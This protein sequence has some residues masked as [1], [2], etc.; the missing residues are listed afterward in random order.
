MSSASSAAQA[1]PSATTP[2]SATVKE[3]DSPPGDESQGNGIGAGAGGPPDK[4][5]KPH[6]PLNRVPRA[7]NACRK[8]K[9]KCT[10]ADNP[11]CKRCRT[12]GIECV[13]EKPIRDTLNNSEQGMRIGRLETQVNSIQSTLSELVT[14]L[15]A[16]VPQAAGALGSH[17]PHPNTSSTSAQASHHHQ[18]SPGNYG[19]PSPST[20]AHST[21]VPSSHGT[22]GAPTD[23]QGPPPSHHYPGPPHTYNNQPMPSGMRQYRST[24]SS[25][26]NR[27]AGGYFSP[28]SHQPPH[29]SASPN[30]MSQ[31]P[32]QLPHLEHAHRNG[33]PVPHQPPM[34]D[35]RSSLH[36]HDQYAQQQP[37]QGQQ[38]HQFSAQ[39]Q[40]QQN[41]Q[42]QQQHHYATQQH[43]VQQQHPSM[44]PPTSL[45]PFSALDVPHGGAHRQTPPGTSPLNVHTGV[46]RA[47]PFIG[48][49]QRKGSGPPSASPVN[50]YN[51]IPPHG[52][53]LQQHQNQPSHAMMN[54]PSAMTQHHQGY[55]PPAGPQAH[56]YHSDTGDQGGGAGTKHGPAV[57][58]SS[59][60][61][62][63][64]SSDDEGG[65]SELPTHGM[66]A[67]FVAIRGLAD[68]AE[69][70]VEENGGESYPT[71]RSGSPS[72][73]GEYYDA[74]A[75]MHGGH[76]D[77]HGPL[78]DPGGRNG[79]RSSGKSGHGTD[80]PSKRRRI[81]SG[82]D[83]DNPEGPTSRAAPDV[84]TKGL[85]S[86]DEAR[87]L[88]QIFFT[89]CSM[90]LP[91]FDATMDT[92]DALH[93]RSP[94][95]V[96]V[97]CM[98]AS[99]VRDGGGPPSE[100][101]KACSKEVRELTCGT[102]F[103]PVMRQEV[104]QA[105]ILVA[106]WGAAPNDSGWLT[107]GHATRMALEL[108]IQKA[109]PRLL[110]RIHAGKMSTS[111]E[112]RELVI[113]S[114]T[115]FCLYL[116]EHQMSFG[117]GRPPVSKEDESVHDCRLL[118]THPLAITDDMRL[119]S[120][121]EL[122]IIRERTHNVVSPTN[123]VPIDSSTFAVLRQSKDNFESW[124]KIWSTNFS[125]KYDVAAFHR[126]SL[127]A[128]VAFAE[129]YHNA[130]ALRTIRGPDDV[131][132]I[133]EDQREVALRSIVV[134]RSALE[135]CLRS[136]SYREGMKYAVQY[137]H[138]S[139]TF[140]A[141]FLMRLARLFPDD[142]DLAA[143]MA[144][145]EDLAVILSEIPAT[146]F[147]RT[148]KLMIRS[149]KRRRVL[150]SS[151]NHDNSM[152][153]MQTD[154]MSRSTSTPRAN[155]FSPSEQALAAVPSFDQV[156]STNGEGYQ[157][158]MSYEGLDQFVRDFELMPGQ[159]VPVWLSE[160]NLGD[161]ALGQHGLEAF[162]I[163]PSLDEQRVVPEIW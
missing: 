102:L 112:E 47:G 27:A 34:P 151:R 110:K 22:G 41:L 163:P 74:D 104:V 58:S 49:P 160:S 7:C 124:L 60:V 39:Q 46:Q 97:I 123:N 134:A 108:G 6:R 2:P 111:Q 28:N 15:R 116:F 16:A 75:H 144:D 3:S 63:A 115:W 119:V 78:V 59:N 139:A 64:D 128:Q 121:V 100:T 20:S 118:L 32:Q 11:P 113:S 155:Q 88:F 150:P 146:R 152:G 44:P 156:M 56:H 120:M 37:H 43:Q 86:E 18:T 95:C 135:V 84:V 101:Y 94:F 138:L 10:D 125:R 70:A 96:D 55:G 31:Q 14:T 73:A 130:T 57:V 66:V 1:G 72:R 26:S 24:S 91:V 140:A 149:A 25:S 71:T 61:T 133:S 21:S 143:I 147:S 53:Q 117:T 103:A 129:L 107:C 85:I 131:A 65:P 83:D 13:F 9:M 137:T 33:D 87:E 158:A 76:G 93:K 54:H 82:V 157:Q 48:P 159:D 23:G 36:Q 17:S 126:Q 136:P 105:M 50:G 127:E 5:Q 42:Q 68:V 38:Y 98:I 69:R 132:R 77:L 161:L 52:A 67:P 114:R 29:L 153:H 148:L 106:G 89:G 81:K 30:S 45:P 141:S 35:H 51:G 19:A 92:F 4:A 145:V 154:Q 62:S 79:K 122:M 99:K 8:Q 162:L 12:A 90:F 80:R 109:W 40:Q 142:C